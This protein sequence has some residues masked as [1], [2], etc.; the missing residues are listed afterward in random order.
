MT[1]NFPP[2]PNVGDTVTGPNGELWAWDGEKWVAARALN[3]GFLQLDGGTLTGPLI[4]AR[5]PTVDLEAATK[6]YVDKAGWDTGDVKFTIRSAAKLP[7]IMCDDGTI[8]NPNSGASTRADDDCRSLFELLFDPPFT[9][10]FVPIFLSNGAATLRASQGDAASAWAAD[11]RMSLTRMLGR[12]LGI[13]GAGAGLSVRA[14]GEIAGTETIT[15]SVAQLAPHQH[16]HSAG[17]YT[18]ADQG[19]GGAG[20]TV[21]VTGWT[22][23]AGGGEPMTITNPTTF[24]NAM[25]HL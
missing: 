2:T 10:A 20:W 17:N 14:L 5:D 24:L 6:Q 12:L 25:I 3:D 22:S 8:G 11:C 16:S 23:V 13:A 4:L 7:W 1:I 15:Q 9:D 21:A 19:A 18:Y